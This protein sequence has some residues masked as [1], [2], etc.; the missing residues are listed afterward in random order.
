MKGDFDG[1]VRGA[2][3]GAVGSGRMAVEEGAEDESPIDWRVAAALAGAIDGMGFAVFDKAVGHPKL[4]AEM[5]SG[6]LK[7]FALHY[8]DFA[9][10]AIFSAAEVGQK[11]M[12][13]IIAGG[14]V[15][16]KLS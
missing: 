14:G 15:V 2:E 13:A 12:D 6:F 11:T 3:L 5:I 10:Y 8:A 9:S 7:S 4:G 16:V 1:T